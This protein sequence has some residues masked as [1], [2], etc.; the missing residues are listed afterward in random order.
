MKLKYRGY[1]DVTTGLGWRRQKNAH[2]ILVGRHLGKRLIGRTSTDL[3]HL[4]LE[5][6]KLFTFTAKQNVVIV[7]NS[8][9]SYL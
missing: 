2:R 4:L 1:N 7:S 8:N 5:I 3:F 9:A 6:L